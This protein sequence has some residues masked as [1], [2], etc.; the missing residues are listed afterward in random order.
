MHVGGVAYNGHAVKLIGWGVEQIGSE[1]VP[2]WLGSNSA[3]SD[4]G[5]NGYFR[6]IRGEDNCRIE[7]YVIAGIMRV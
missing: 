2:Y 6:I 5:E 1:K 7:T 4:W 3:N